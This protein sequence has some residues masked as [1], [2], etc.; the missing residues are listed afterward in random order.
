VNPATLAVAGLGLAAAVRGG[1]AGPLGRYAAWAAV[2]VAAASI[3]IALAG[4]LGVFEQANAEVVALAV[5]LNI[6][7]AAALWVGGGA[8]S[9]PVGVRTRGG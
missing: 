4:T 6:G 8:P 9:R 2:A 1:I 7:L 3:L 5:P